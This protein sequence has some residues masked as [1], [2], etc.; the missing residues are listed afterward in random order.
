MQAGLSAISLQ[1][2]SLSTFFYDQGVKDWKKWGWETP[3]LSIGTCGELT[4]PELSIVSLLTP[5][6]KT[7]SNPD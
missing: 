1:S 2:L 6:E 4:A 5:T 3:N 7:F